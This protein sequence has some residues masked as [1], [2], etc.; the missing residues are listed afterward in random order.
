MGHV[1]GATPVWIPAVMMSL[2]QLGDGWEPLRQ[3]G[4][5]G[6]NLIEVGFFNA[7]LTANF[8]AGAKR[9]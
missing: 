2:S 3:I 5:L 4:K 6:Q 8:A 1:I 9:I 7:A